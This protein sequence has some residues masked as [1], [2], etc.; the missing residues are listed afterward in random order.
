MLRASY[1]RILNPDE[2]VAV[3][4]DGVRFELRKIMC[5]DRKKRPLRDEASQRALFLLSRES[6]LS[7]NRTPSKITATTSSGFRMRR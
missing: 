2:V 3:I 5:D 6:Y 7:S 1:R 4:L